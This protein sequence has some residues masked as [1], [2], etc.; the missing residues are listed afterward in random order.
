MNVQVCLN[1]MVTL[2][3]QTQKQVG[4]EDGSKVEYDYLVLASGG[5]VHKY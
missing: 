3:N 5:T 2:V 4:L 1:T